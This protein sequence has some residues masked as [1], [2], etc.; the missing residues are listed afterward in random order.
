MKKTSSGK[1]KLA[2]AAFLAAALWP[3]PLSAAPVSAPAQTNVVPHSTFILPNS[4]KDGIDPF[5]PNSTRPYENT[6]QATHVTLITSLVLKGISGPAG[7]RLAIINNHTFGADEQGDV[8][9]PGG[10]VH[11]H[12]LQI[13]EKTAVIEAGGQRRELTLPGEQ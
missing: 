10:K 3:A 12:V 5:F 2:A 9:V 11:V 8:I 4:P 6:V 13:N 1:L 7:N